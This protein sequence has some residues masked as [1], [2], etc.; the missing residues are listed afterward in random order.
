M[1]QQNYP[2]INQTLPPMRSSLPQVQ[3]RYWFRYFLFFLIIVILFLGLYFF[4]SLN[5]RVSADS[6]KQNFIVAQGQGLKV[7][8]ANLQAKGLIKT[9]LIFEIYSYATG[10]HTKIQAGVYSLAPN[11]SE[12][13]IITALSSGAKNE[14]DVKRV[15]EG[16]TL[17][18]LANTF[19]GSS[20]SPAKT[21]FLLALQ[22][23]AQSFDYFG[24]T[25]KVK[26]LEGYL[27]PD[28]YFFAKNAKPGD[29][30]DKILANTDAKL[31]PAI[32]AEIKAQNRSIYSVLTLA[33]IVEKEVGRNQSTVSVEDLKNLQNEREI[34]AGIFI[35]RL[36]QGMPLQSDATVTFITKKN[37][38]SATIAD[39]KIDSPYN[40][41][42][43]AGLPPGPISNPSLSSILAAINY[44]QTDYL[45]FL[46]EPNGTAHFAKTLDE[47][48]QNKAKYL[49]R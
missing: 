25:P 30:I 19:Y 1:E 40:T 8:T 31:T 14:Y 16:S 9:P 3:K 5:S 2:V 32:R 11:M 29:I 20:D 39:T 43:Y 17:Q 38:P 27:F 28:T 12:K 10:A 21:S 13:E 15:P 4:Y 7:V 36:A 44:R 24:E 45:Y 22:V 34:V 47:Q 41:Y 46:T 33:S 37:N 23:K 35:N 26:S 49:N 48:N 42:K 6:T 18:D